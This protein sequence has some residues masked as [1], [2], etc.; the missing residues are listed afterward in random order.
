[1]EVRPIKTPLSLER[2]VVFE[3]K[4]SVLEKYIKN[5]HPS[6]RRKYSL[7]ASPSYDHICLISS[8]LNIT[9]RLFG[10]KRTIFCIKGIGEG[11]VATGG[12]DRTLRIW[13]IKKLKQI[14]VFTGGH[15]DIITCIEYI[16]DGRIATGSFDNNICI[17]DIN[18]GCITITLNGHHDG[19]RLLLVIENTLISA[20]INEELRVWELKTWSMINQRKDSGKKNLQISKMLENEYILSQANTISILNIDKNGDYNGNIT[21]DSGRFCF[22][23]IYISDSEIIGGLSDGAILLLELKRKEQILNIK[24]KLFIWESGSPIW[25]L[26]PISG[27]NIIIVTQDRPMKLLNLDSMQMK[28]S[29]SIY[30]VKEWIIGVIQIEY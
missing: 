1:M 27:K 29:Y 21:L 2:R 19:L 6:L 24:F 25:G 10:H 3:Y 18:L 11:K 26:I 13:D 8:T 22:S 12:M 14:N 30:W 23:I 7:L 4:I 15:T 17:W 28:E 20:D 16:S 9:G 5:L